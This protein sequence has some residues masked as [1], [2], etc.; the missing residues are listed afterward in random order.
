MNEICDSDID[1]DFDED[2]VSSIRYNDCNMCHKRIDYELRACYN[3]TCCYEYCDFCCSTMMFLLGPKYIEEKRL[4]SYTLNDRIPYYVKKCIKC[5]ADEDWEIYIKDYPF[6][7][8]FTGI[9]T[10]N[11]YRKKYKYGRYHDNSDSDED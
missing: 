5:K 3:P 4:P 7:N 6:K 10:Y 1:S 11:R 9:D 8:E 2:A